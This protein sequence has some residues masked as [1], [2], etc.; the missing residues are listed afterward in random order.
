MPLTQVQAGMLATGVPTRAQLPSGSVLQVVN[1]STGAVATGT[2][3]I[4]SDDTIPQNTEGD[5]YMSLAVTPTS[6]TNNLRIDV[7]VQCSSSAGGG[8]MM[9][10]LFQDSTAN[11]LAVSTQGFIDANKPMMLSFTHYMTAGTTS[12]TTFKVRVGAAQAG[13]T[14]FNGVSGGRLYGGVS[15]SSITI[16]EI[17]A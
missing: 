15:S 11:A 9:A 17:A 16:M 10:A 2:T 7:V 4:P 12:A 5:Q 8:R 3:L 14:T 6:A 1:S 13:T